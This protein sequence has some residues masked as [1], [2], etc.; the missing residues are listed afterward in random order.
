MKSK[1]P[2]PTIAELWGELQSYIDFFTRHT[3]SGNPHDIGEMNALRQQL[4]ER[5]KPWISWNA[6][7]SHYIEPRVVL[8]N[9]KPD[10]LRKVATVYEFAA[11]E[12][13]QRQREKESANGK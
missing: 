6:D 1:T 2:T 12:I 5:C 9:A 13:E 3:L 8:Y 4:V 7:G 11:F 10:E